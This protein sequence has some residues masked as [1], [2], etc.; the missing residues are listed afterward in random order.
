MRAH[1][2]MEAQGSDQTNKYAECYPGRRYYGGCQYVDIA[3]NLAIERAKQ[4]FNCGFANVQPNS[5]LRANQG[6]N[7]ALLLLC[8][9]ILVMNHASACHLI[10]RAA[11]NQPGKWL[12]AV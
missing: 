3:E 4:L 10:H 5:G 1:A 9:T 8:D 7:H 2:G 12:N 11:P 6:V